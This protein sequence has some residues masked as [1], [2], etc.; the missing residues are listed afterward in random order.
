MNDSSGKSYLAGFA[1]VGL[2]WFLVAS[3][4]NIANAGQLSGM[5]R[6]FIKNTKLYSITLCNIYG[7]RFGSWFRCYDG[8]ISKRCLFTKTRSQR[9]KSLRKHL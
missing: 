4:L 5:G 6:W 1:I 8:F 2:M 7:R 9:R 3:I